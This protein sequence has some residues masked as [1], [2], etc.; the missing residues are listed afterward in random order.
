MAPPTTRITVFGGTWPAQIWRL[1][2]LHAAPTFPSRDFPSPDVSYVSVAVDVT[3]D[4]YCLPNAYTL[5]QNIETLQFIAGTEPTLTCT[6]PTELQSVTVPS[7]IGLS[8]AAATALL[9][10]AGFYVNVQ[11]AVSTQP[12][13]T[14]IS[15][16]PS[17]GTSAYQ[18]ST[19]TITV[20]KDESATQP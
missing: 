6:T 15:Q 10:Q 13:G 18:T 4:P 17:A 12:A 5:P 8:Q 9:E 7:V 3:Q 1:F 2:M 11:I 16:S 14:V 20:S 19:I